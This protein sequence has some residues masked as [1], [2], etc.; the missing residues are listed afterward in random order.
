MP[1]RLQEIEGTFRR[2]RYRF[3]DCIIGEIELPANGTPGEWLTIK[4]D[5]EDGEL[6]RGGRYRFYGRFAKYRN[7]RSGVEEKQ[8]HFQTFVP[9]LAHDR[10]GVVAYLAAA[11]QGFGMGK[12]TAEKAFDKFG[13][14]AVSVIRQSPRELLSLNNRITPEQCDAIADKL[15]QQKATEDATIELTSLL[16]GRGLPKV[17]SRNAI[18]KW[19]NQAAE[20]VKRDPYSLMNFR[21][22]G[23]KLCDKL[24]LEMGLPADKLR[25]QALC[26]WH[27]VASQSDGHTWYPAM[28][29]VQAIRQAI[30]SAKA[31][32]KAA[33]GLAMR[34][35]RLSPDHYGALAGIKTDGAS[36]PIKEDGS[37]PWLAE[38]RAAKS[39]ESLA[40][41]LAEAIAES[42]PKPI[43]S[44]GQE[45]VSW[46]EAVEAIKCNRCGR[47]LTAPEVHVWDGK[48]F[49]PTCIG[50]ISDGTDVDVLP[51]GDWFNQQP[52]IIRSQIVTVPRGKID[53]PPFSLWPDPTNIDGIDQHQRD[54]LTEALVSRVAIL[55]GSPGTGK[56]YA[57][58]MLIRALLKSGRV[59]PEDIAIG[60]PTGK[61][62]VRLTEALQAAGVELTARTWH[63]LL[64]VGQSEDRGGW[65]FLHNER[66]PWTFRVIVGDESSMVDLSLMRS[67]FAARPRG[68]HVLLVGDVHQLPPVGA[69]APLRDMIASKSIGYGEL[70]EIKRN[71]GGI[72]EAC[73]AI[74]D[75]QRWEPGDNLSIWESDPE[76]NEIE[77]A[78]FLLD[79]ARANGFDPVWDCQVL[80]AV[81]DRS[82]LSRKKINRILQQELNTNPEVKGTPF[83]QGDKIVCLKNG[84]YPMVDK[85]A[86]DEV[87]VANGELAEVI[88]V[89]DKRLLA[90]LIISRDEVLIPRGN[91][92]GDDDAATGCNWDLA[93]ALSV[94]KSQGSE[95]PVVIVMLDDYAGARLVCDRSWLYT[96]ISRAKSKCFLVGRRHVADAMCRN[97]AIGKRRTLLREQLQRKIA[98]GVIEELA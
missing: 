81:N 24:Y 72:V 8:F 14:D 41:M 27:S 21:G 31:R 11:G 65:S 84:R 83:R 37:H 22:C 13:G 36:G 69:G 64:G 98:K 86:G 2:Q 80:V 35:G 5:A 9:A 62:A 74:R 59:G 88:A 87:Y 89:E 53:L 23:F 44:F 95:W 76:K 19:G 33:V 30:G 10:E 1:A 32:P 57:T 92:S 97:Q 63:S 56:T 18:K 75:C 50:Y 60:A 34:L 28:A 47:L 12:A 48:P 29:V 82:E 15:N 73:A 85:D 4:G 51:L 45:I 78:I 26:A 71:S 77:R 93:Y 61:A 39:E 20:I 70:T 7:K 52:D 3:D 55:G 43:T 91:S 16:A 54:K 17:T 66:N 90:K 42:S 25:R 38:G 94:H 46:R 79:R 96:A 58:A 40:S 49:G 68:C 67:I 6:I